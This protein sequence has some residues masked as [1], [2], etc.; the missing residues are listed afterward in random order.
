MSWC[1]KEAQILDKCKFLK[2]PNWKRVRIGS[3]TEVKPDVALF[4]TY[5]FPDEVKI[6]QFNV[7]GDYKLLKIDTSIDQLEQAVSK[8]EKEVA[9]NYCDL[10]KEQFERL[11]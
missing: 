10:K 11:F 3:M 7:F 4:L 1:T 2:L 9:I 5:G 8:V 6:F